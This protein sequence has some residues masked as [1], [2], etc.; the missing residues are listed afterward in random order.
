MKGKP[1][2]APQ[3]TAFFGHPAGLKTL[4]FAE[5][6][7]RFSFYG[8]K[9]L[10][11]LFLPLA[12]EEG[13]L[14]LGDARAGMVLA[15]YTSLVYLSNLPGGWVAD[16][17]LGPRRAVLVGGTLILAGHVCLAFHG[18]G[19]FAAGLAL[20]VAGT[21]LL[22]PNMTAMVG[23]LYA[24]GD[25]RRDAG[26]SLY[27]LGI[28][29]GAFLAPL[30][31]GTLAQHEGFRRALAWAGIDPRQSWHFGFA[32]AAVGMS[33]G[34]V[35]YVRGAGRLGDV[36][37]RHKTAQP[38]PAGRRALAVGL[39]AAVLLVAGHASGV[40][41]ITLERVNVGL[42]VALVVVPAAFFGRLLLSGE[43]TAEQKKRLAV[44]A[45]LFAF[46][47]VFFAASEQ[48]AGTLNVFAA[49]HTD[50]RLAGFAFPSSWFQLVNP[51]LILVLTPA[52][53]GLWQRLG[54]RQPSS[55]AKFVIALL[56]TGVSFTVMAG[57]ARLAAATGERVSP[58][59]LTAVYFL[60]TVAELCISP[61]GLSLA[62]RL[63]PARVAGQVTG[64]WFIA[65]ALGNYLAGQALVASQHFPLA[66]VFGF[67][68]AVNLAA[69]LALLPLLR[70]ARALT[71]G[72]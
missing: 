39:A 47:A 1:A 27:Y 11:V 29:V 72:G 50:N 69:G 25:P 12:V 7:E 20:V 6:W 8:M 21:G 4:F 43:L 15:I 62:T 42:G 37:L 70:R 10:L 52:F 31:C 41:P 59:W 18:A 68:A 49:R 9:P 23:Q 51:L 19:F 40:S 17:F 35:Q 71:A 61:V 45:T 60:I 5:M 66:A 24:P 34:L 13:G 64:V 26:F 53:A 33:F 44:L 30:V 36:G 28:N 56:V 32:A 54:E 63:A 22:K 16:R 38:A 2:G 14:G 58:F 3:D 55:P 46:S 48:S 57:A 67:T 65:A